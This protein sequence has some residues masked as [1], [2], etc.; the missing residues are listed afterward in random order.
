MTDI[1][2][3][4]GVHHGRRFIPTVIDELANTEPSST[5]LSLPIDD[6]DVSKGYQDITYGRL[7]NSIDHDVRWLNQN[8]LTSQEP[9]QTFAYAGAKDICYPIL[10]VAAAK[11]GKIVDDVF[12]FCSAFAPCLCL[13][14]CFL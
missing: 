9:L 12:S 14:R 3:F 4:L 2:P 11:I 8:L 7:A 10:A 6:L 1:F 5:W 13:S